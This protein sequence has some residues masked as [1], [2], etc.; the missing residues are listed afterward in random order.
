M[1]VQLAFQKRSLLFDL[2]DLS[3]VPAADLLKVEHIFVSHTHM[4]HFIGFDQLLRLFLGRAKRLHLYGPEGFLK[5]VAAK[6]SA[7]TWN[8]VKNYDDALELEVSEI[9]GDR[10][11]TQTFNCRTGF[12]PTAPPQVEDSGKILHEERALR[13]S[14]V[15]L[16]HQ[17][18]CLSFNLQEHFHINILKNQLEGLCLT[19]GPW[20][21]S[22]KKLLY[23]GADPSTKILVPSS[24]PNQQ[25]QTFTV[26]E[27]RTKVARI[28]RG[29]KIAYVTDTKYTPANEEKI[30]SLAHGADHLFIEAAFLDKDRDIAQA[31][32]HLTA[33][34]AGAI[35]RKACVRKVT[36][37]HF[38]PRY[39]DAGNQLEAEAQ[40]AFE[41]LI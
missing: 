18:P 4:D 23:A 33:R 39:T 17:I 26:E 19:V 34:Q 25:L 3:T 11:M 28:S 21:N 9:E 29:Q 22:F 7:Y 38:S 30:I 36:V 41:G 15:I 6:L 13:V 35:A 24:L 32:Y 10:K 16:D 40:M 20:I 5:N 8:L 1:L 37:F 2:G 14:A 27:L 12:K 31:K